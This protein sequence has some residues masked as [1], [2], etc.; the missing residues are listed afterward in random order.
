MIK[1]HE[2]LETISKHPLSP[3]TG[4]L[5]LEEINGH[6]LNEDV[7]ADRDFPPF[8][9]VTMDGISI[10]YESYK[11]GQRR[12]E[13]E[14]TIGAG[15][16]QASLEDTSKCMQIMT[17]AMLPLNA[18][19]VI[20][21]EDITIEEDIATINIDTIKFQQNVHFKGEDK[22]QGAIVLSK[23][24]VLGAPEMII[25]ASI[26][27]P[28][29]EVLLPP[30]AAIITTGDE[31]VGIDE[32]PLDHE[33]RRSSNY[34]VQDLLKIW[35]IN[36]KQHHLKDD[37]EL[38]KSE[39]SSIIE[40]VDLLVLTGGVSRGKFDFLPEVLEELGVVKHFHKVKQRPGKPFWFGTT[41]NGTTVFALP[42]NPVST[43]AC[44]NIYIRHWLELSLGIQTS[45]IYV[46]LNQDIE[47]MPPL[48]YFLECSVE[49]NE[50]GELE[51]TPIRGHGSGDFANMSQANGFII[52]PSDKN[53]FKKGE[54]YPYLFYRKI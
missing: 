6:V 11:N 34:G 50:R 53:K 21:Y 41:P 35:N 46:K 33:I 51:A 45:P 10:N 18:D 47:F 2:A 12:F 19:T 31:L 23:G 44:A 27:R 28:N 32:T 5:S 54:V 3:K 37:K 40:T 24:T 48:T 20:R 49:S 13:I 1:Y 26:G 38:M 43:F 39:L 29:L 30:K 4:L 16:P 22:K 14:N 7:Y 36:A 42:G 25:A 15:M 8:D 52:L 9:R 17:G